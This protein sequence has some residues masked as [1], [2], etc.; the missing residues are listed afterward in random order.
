MPSIAR[1]ALVSHSAA[2]MYSL[3]CDIESYPQF[4]PWCDSA[5]VAEQSDTHQVA[6]V[7]V[8]RRLRGIQFTTRNTLEAEKAI[9]LS[10]VNGPFKRLRGIWKF[11]A[12]SEDAC[13][14]ELEMDFEFSSKVLGVVLGPAF[15]KI[16]DS[17]VQ[18]FVRRADQIHK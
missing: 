15:A 17:M 4:L 10:L 8:D 6:T 16:C 1:S 2:E 14:V 11:Q 13:K 9:H 7:V 5:S 18:A 3:V 12:V